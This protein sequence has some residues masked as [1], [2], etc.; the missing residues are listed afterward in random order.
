MDP[1]F[2][3]SHNLHKVEE[4]R[5]LLAPL[6][7]EVRPL[8]AGLP[9][10]PEDGHSFEANAL[11]KAVFY[12]RW[13]DGWVLAD[14][15]GLCVDALQGAPGVNSARYSGVHGDD[16]ANNQKLLQ[17]LAGT[18]D[19]QR[20]AVFVCALAVWSRQTQAGWVV[21]GAVRGRIAHA[22]RGSYGFGYDPLFILSA[23]GCTMAELSAEEKQQVSHRAE[24]VRRLLQQWGV[25]R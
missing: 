11:E 8:P 23:T 6:Q 24:A 14:D 22:P 12:S 9:T 16:A 13:C 1:I 15:S 25:G 5:Q 10:C 4:F 20:T 18:P 19:E 3:A 2:I 7:A 21:R 17:A